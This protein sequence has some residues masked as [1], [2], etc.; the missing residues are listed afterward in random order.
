MTEQSLDNSVRLGRF[1]CLVLRHKPGAAGIGL[2]EHGWANVNDL[3]VGINQTGRF[4]TME[5]L[6]K[7]VKEDCKNRYSFNGDHTKIRANQGHSLIGID[8]ELKE[9]TPPAMLYHGTAERFLPSIK[10][11][12]IQ[13]QQRLLVN[14][15]SDIETALSVGRR[16]G[17][18]VVL[19]VNTT[20]MLQKGFKF[21]LSEN[22]VW[23]CDSVP[24]DYCKI[25]HLPI[26]ALNG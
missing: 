26:N 5:L 3:I 15:S 25:I 6:E 23:L 12:G 2:D 19:Q 7:I 14:L 4:I 24:F 9:E 8:I 17:H 20:P 22:K 11:H 10:K 16:H 1:L 13:R 18:P 21:F